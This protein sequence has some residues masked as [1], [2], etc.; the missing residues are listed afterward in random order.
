M[1]AKK[2]TDWSRGLLLAI[3]P[4]WKRWR[5]FARQGMNASRST[6][7][8]VRGDTTLCLVAKP[9]LWFQLPSHS[10]F[11]LHSLPQTGTRS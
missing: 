7:Q 3:G 10:D 6:R 4:F 2:Q 11:S 8:M 9:E 1:H 5:H